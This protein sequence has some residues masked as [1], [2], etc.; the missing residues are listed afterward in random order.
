MRNFF[1]PVAW[2]TLWLGCLLTS[3]LQAQDWKKIPIPPLPA[4]HP[5]QP[6]RVELPNGMVV[7]LQEDHELPLIDLT[8]SIR[9]GSRVEPAAKVGL[10]SMYGEVW[11]TGGTKNQTG[12]QLDDYLEIR[13]AKVETGG[14]SDSTAISLA[15]LKEDFNDVFKVF[16]DL[17]RQPEFRA[18]KL[19]LAK[20]EA[21]DA[22]S[23]RNDEISQ[24]A[25]R[26]AVR[27]A[28]GRDN[29]YA[30]QPEYVTVSAVTR[31]DLL[32]WHKT[33]VYPNN[34]ILGVV[35]D[36][37]SA[38]ME[39][40]LR[41]AFGSWGKGPAAKPPE[42]QFSPAKPGY[43][44]IKKEDVN[45]SWIRMVGL[46]TTRNNPDYYAIE[47]FNEAFGGGFSAR[48]IQSIRTA[49]GLAYAV[50][51]GIGTRFD[52]PGILQ[53][54]MA[55][56]SQSTVQ[57]IQALHEQIDQ[58]KTKPVTDDEIKR[59]KDTILNNFVF[60]FDTP[61]KVL[62]ERMAYEFYGYPADFL[63]RYRSGI[64]KVTTAD[65]ARVAAK[66]VHKDQ[67][68]VLVA[69][70]TAEFD[71]PLSS[72]GPVADVDI[73]IPPPPGESGGEGGGGGEKKST[74][75]QGKALAAKV[76]E[77]LGGEAKLESVKSVKSN[78]TVTQMAGPM[79][80]TI[81]AESTIVFPD[82][83][84]LNMQTSQGNFS[85][86]VTPAGAFMSAEGMGT[87]DM[88]TSRKGEIMEQIHRDIIYVAQHVSDPA[89]S[90]TSSG[91]EPP[92]ESKL[93][94]VDVSGPGVNLRWF[95][96][97]QSGK[98]VRQTY[99]VTGTSGPADGETV[100]SDWRQVEGLN[101]PFHRANKQN[102]QDSSATQY[103]TIQLNPV[104][105]AKIFEKPGS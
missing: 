52:H 11:R 48:L 102:G 62:H 45:Q 1:R 73:T 6:K 23:R 41:A 93:A 10:V 20:H 81:Q 83:S 66:Y 32:A 89:F 64:E 42:I 40:R 85:I 63:E 3:T 77:A 38:Q 60:N 70:N 29:A 99:K 58:L 67:L 74:N 57:A 103:T 35:G 46:G 56:K 37:D 4:F 47:V 26:E 9:G 24:V 18:D 31:E 87:Q 80:G 105:D 94:A 36:F 33:Y 22:I 95:V 104:I 101:L 49:Q 59:A 44:L 30:R 51:G 76:V 100:F 90:F 79:Q 5:Q 84:R 53:L 91:N 54:A 27:L 97:P 71:K 86:V 69:G 98:I 39:A 72:L 2:C 82:Q 68:A 21:F 34:I 14:D 75:P 92:A 12:D 43:Y 19:E 17:L 28:Y 8:A 88:P 65:V 13:A 55:T 78:F 15:C 25:R 16:S 61:D 96:D 7:F 50:G